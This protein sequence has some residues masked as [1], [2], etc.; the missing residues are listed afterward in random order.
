MYCPALSNS[1]S[2]ILTGSL[3]HPAMSTNKMGIIFSFQTPILSLNLTKRPFINKK[4]QVVS[5]YNTK[6][7]NG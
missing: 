7:E 3:E 1:T 4:H 2:S 5:L 6:E